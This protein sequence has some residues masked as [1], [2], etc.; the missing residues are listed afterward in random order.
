MKYD[1]TN[2]VVYASGNQKGKT[3]KRERYANMI[4]YNFGGWVYEGAAYATEGRQYLF[5][6]NENGTVWVA[7]YRAFRDYIDKFDSPKRKR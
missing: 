7:D 5:R 2:G 3:V 6:S 4:G 1:I